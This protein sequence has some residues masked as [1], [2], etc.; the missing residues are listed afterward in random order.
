[1]KSLPTVDLAFFSMQFL[2]ILANYKAQ[3]EQ[4]KARQ[5]VKK[6]YSSNCNAAKLEKSR[7]CLLY[8]KNMLVEN[9]RIVNISTIYYRMVLIPNQEFNEKTQNRKLLLN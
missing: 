5:K 6:L 1:M 7:M 3:F 8:K 9:L 2:L 4:P